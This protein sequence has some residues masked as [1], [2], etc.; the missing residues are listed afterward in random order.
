MVSIRTCG[1]AVSLE[2]EG[3]QVDARGRFLIVNVSR[4]A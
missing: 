4:S 1:G 2:A 3:P